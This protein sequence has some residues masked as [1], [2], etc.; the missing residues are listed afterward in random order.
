MDLNLQ[1][2]AHIVPGEED[3][4]GHG[5]EGDTSGDS[6]GEEEAQPKRRR[7]KD[8]K[9]KQIASF[10]SSDHYKGS[11]IFTELN[12]QMSRK[13]VTAA[14]NSKIEWFECLYSR[15]RG[16]KK[17]PKMY[18]ASFPQS[19]DEVYVYS[20]E[21]DHDHEEDDAHQTKTNYHWTAL[22]EDVI[23]RCIKTHVKSNKLILRELRESNMVNADGRLPTATQVHFFHLLLI[24]LP[25]KA[26][27]YKHYIFYD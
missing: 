1:D 21:D 15:K 9:W 6:E 11:D 14:G 16:Y 10:P 20:T 5:D 26:L 3:F 13:R 8:L 19:S 4:I 12:S 25:H 23:R 24:P 2:A 17:C 22:Q 18:K 27:K 7:G